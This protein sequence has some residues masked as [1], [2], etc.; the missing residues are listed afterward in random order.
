[1]WKQPL[2]ERVQWLNINFNNKTV[3]NFIIQDMRALFAK[4]IYNCIWMKWDRILMEKDVRNWKRKKIKKK[5][6]KETNWRRRR[7]KKRIIIRT[8][9]DQK[10][11]QMAIKQHST[12]Q[13]FFCFGCFCCCCCSF[14]PR[15]EEEGIRNILCVCCWMHLKHSFLRQ[16]GRFSNYDLITHKKRIFTRLN[17]FAWQIANHLLTWAN[18]LIFRHFYIGWTK[19]TERKKKEFGSNAAIIAPNHIN[20]HYTF[21]YSII[22]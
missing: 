4:Y 18:A 10:Q 3:Y 2:T 12:A 16:R 19:K 15:E 7:K 9:Y 22:Q 20:W 5:I 21:K 1:M 8:A 11:D 13:S 6:K 17:S 14:V